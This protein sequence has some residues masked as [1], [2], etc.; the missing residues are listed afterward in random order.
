MN[1]K[2][3]KDILNSISDEEAEKL[4]VVVEIRDD[5]VG[6]TPATEIQSAGCGFDW[7]VNRFMLLPKDPLMPHIERIGNDRPRQKFI[8]RMGETTICQCP[9][10]RVDIDE[11][12]KFCK[13][14]GQ[15]L[16]C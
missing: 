5:T 9:V 1:A 16:K 12:D 8:R 4:T 13:N 7:D 11:L 10:C 6:P 2:R 14:C 3:L 15:K